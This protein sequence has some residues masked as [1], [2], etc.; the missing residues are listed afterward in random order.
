MDVTDW[1]LGGLLLIFALGLAGMGTDIPNFDMSQL[2]SAI[3]QPTPTRTPAQVQPTTPPTA[4]S[5]PTAN[6]PTSQPTVKITPTVTITVSARPLIYGI[7]P[8][9]STDDAIDGMLA[10]IKDSCAKVLRTGFDWS[11]IHPLTSVW[12]WGAYDKIYN[13]ATANNIEIVALIVQSPSWANGG[14]DPSFTP[15]DD[16]HKDDY[17]DFL[18]QMAAKYPRIKYYEFWNE[19]N[20]D[21]WRPRYEGCS[22]QSR[23]DEYLKWMKVTYETLKSANPN[24]LV[25][26]TGDS[27]TDTSWTQM[28]YARST[29]TN[30]CGGKPCWDAIGFHSYPIDFDGRLKSTHD[31]MVAKGE[32]T[33]PIWITEYGRKN[34]GMNAGDI[35]NTLNRLASTE[36]SY[37]T[38]ATYHDIADTDNENLGLLDTDLNPKPNGSFGAF[39]SI[40]CKS[41]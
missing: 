13:F 32:S 39:Q 17:I 38:I 22:S 34:G 5:T 41:K 25:S 6:Q 19:A 7:N 24:I 28:L 36:F 35:T 15:P 1:V 40:A 8:P 3:I 26:T 30:T 11:N 14:G 18:K 4:S 23:A 10:K 31:L 33:K 21:G 2:A 16:A 9:S 37:V 12:S 20:C 29:G 27:S